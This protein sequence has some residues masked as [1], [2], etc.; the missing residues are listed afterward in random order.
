MSKTSRHGA[1]EEGI[2]D[3]PLLALVDDRKLT[4]ERRERAHGRAVRNSR[5]KMPRCVLR[6]ERTVPLPRDHGKPPLRRGK[7]KRL[8]IEQVPPLLKFSRLDCSLRKEIQRLQSGS[9]RLITRLRKT[10]VLAI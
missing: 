6:S 1:I 5:K 7:T 3:G 10:A 8:I 2:F 4:I 9:L